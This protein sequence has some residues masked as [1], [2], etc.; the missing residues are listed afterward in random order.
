MDAGRG[1]G[2]EVGFLTL[3]EADVGALIFDRV[4]ESKRG[5]S[6]A[7]KLNNSSCQKESYFMKLDHVTHFG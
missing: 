2:L 3:E 1:G 4:D 5:I 6:A 7:S